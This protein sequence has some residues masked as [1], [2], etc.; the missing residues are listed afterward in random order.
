MI[1][2]TMQGVRS[3][4]DT[5]TTEPLTKI[6]HLIIWQ[7]LKRLK[8]RQPKWMNE[9]NFKAHCNVLTYKIKPSVHLVSHLVPF[10]LHEATWRFHYSL[11][12]ECNFISGGNLLPPPPSPHHFVGLHWQSLTA[13]L[14]FRMKGGSVRVLPR[15]TLHEVRKS[16]RYERCRTKSTAQKVVYG[17]VKSCRLR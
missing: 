3:D 8:G 10:P 15:I 12:M 4:I 5:R 7:L 2:K 13:W 11:W 9:K 16:W 6:S 17:F 14:Y 1:S